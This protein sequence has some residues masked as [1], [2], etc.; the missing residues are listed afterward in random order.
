MDISKQLMYIDNK[1][2]LMDFNFSYEFIESLKLTKGLYELF[3]MKLLKRLSITYNESNQIENIDNEFIKFY[4]QILSIQFNLYDFNNY[5]K[6]ILQLYNQY[7]YYIIKADRITKHYL[8]QHKFN[9]YNKIVKFL[10]NT[11]IPPL[12]IQQNPLCKDFKLLTI[13]YDKQDRN[14]FT[15]LAHE[16]KLKYPKKYPKFVDT[17]ELMYN[18]QLNITLNNANNIILSIKSLYGNM[19]HPL[20]KKIYTLHIFNIKSIMQTLK[21]TKKNDMYLFDYNY[22]PEYE[23]TYEWCKHQYIINILINKSN[24]Y[25]IYIEELHKSKSQSIIGGI[26]DFLALNNNT[27]KFSIVCD[28]YYDNKDFIIYYINKITNP[29]YKIRMSSIILQA[30]YNENNLYSLAELNNIIDNLNIPNDI[31]QKYGTIIISIKNK[32]KLLNDFIKNKGFILNYKNNIND[33]CLIC[34]EEIN[35]NII[36][37]IECKHC[38]KELGHMTCLLRWLC[39]NNN[40]CPNCRQ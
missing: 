25:N 16:I 38:K 35:S 8:L 15:K 20:L 22:I 24:D 17:L 31:Y 30:L 9:M 3:E 21:I 4:Y 37:T 14:E 28:F 40:K 18:F 5:K 32:I 27:K 39:F 10:D 23:N 19:L 33:I 6:Q 26:F 36:T 29:Q 2:I 1:L 7:D 34:H 12:N 13:L 11:L